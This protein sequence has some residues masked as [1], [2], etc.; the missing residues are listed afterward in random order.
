M[1]LVSILI[2]F[3]TISGVFAELPDERDAWN[4]FKYT[5]FLVFRGGYR[6]FTVR[7]NLYYAGLAAPSLWYAFDHDDRMVSLASSK[8]IKKHEEFT[9]DLGVA[10]N[11]PIIPVATYVMGRTK[12]NDKMV[13]FAVEYAASMYLALIE[14]NLLSWI[15]IHDRPD[16]TALSFWEKAFRS[17][18]S[19]PSGHVVPYAILML[20]GF[21]YYGPWTLIPT[22]IL[23]YWSAFQRMHGKKHYF[24][25]VVGGLFLSVFASEGVRAAHNHDKNHPVYKWIFEHEV[26]V[27]ILRQKG[28]VGPLVSWSF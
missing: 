21:Q 28:A 10:L 16:T 25:D 23:F 12:Q 7:N 4:D 17:D 6:Q 26:R 1:L 27:G 24:S 22:S 15:H 2:G 14:S 19:F 8:E 13:N 11:F 3:F 18:S 9:G 20:K 5:F